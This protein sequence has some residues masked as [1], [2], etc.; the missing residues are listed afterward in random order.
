[1]KIRY[2]L[3]SLLFIMS[4]GTKIYSQ[5]DRIEPPFWWTEMKHGKLQLMVH[6]GNIADFSV[7]IAYDGVSIESVE[8]LDSDNYLFINLIISPEAK[9]G[10]VE[11]EFFDGDDP[12]TLKEYDL[13]E[14]EPGSA[15]R[16]GY[17]NS[18]VMYL[19]MPDRFVNGDPGNDT[20]EGMKEGLNRRKRFGRHGGDIAGIRNNLGYM[21][22]MGFTAIWLNPVLEN[23]MEEASYHGY[24]AT[25]FYRVDRRLGT[26]EEYVSL[27]S[28]AK[29]KGMK[30][31][32]DMIFNHCGSAHWWM[33]DLPSGDWINYGGKYHPSNHMRTVNQDP[34]AS[35][36]DKREMTDGWFVPAMPDL[37]QKNPFMAEYLIQNSIWWIEYAGI[38]GIRM[39]TYPY[40][41]KYMMAEWNRRISTEYPDFNIVGE[42]WSM[43]PAIVSYW[44][45]GQQNRD[46]YSGGLPGLM[47]FPLQDAVVKALNEKEEWGKGLVRIYEMLANDFLYPNPFNLVILPDNH[48]MPRFY[49]QLGM[50][51]YLFRNGIVFFLTTRG[52]PQIFYG[53]EILMTHK[54]GNDHGYIRKDF[55]GGWTGDKVNAFNG[56]GLGKEEK[57]MQNMFRRILNWRKQTPVIHTGRLLQF[58][59]EHGTYVYF[60]YDENDMVMVILNKNTSPYD[61]KLDRF[62]EMLHG[63][64]LARD[65]LSG[66]EYELGDKLSLSPGKPYI[67]EIE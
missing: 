12:V 27:V 31:I 55:P 16:K 61:L 52:V 19:I 50:N 11:L 9:P 21:T 30:V 1:M 3:L 40:P 44:Q 53:T 24:A 26:N 23:D 48:D 62:N 45:R 6:G 58:V 64:T 47:D 13:L 15:D 51:R 25:D 33:N 35:E 4:T 36:Y 22:D 67:L 38:S 7:N 18:D 28:E 41:D 8:R 17:D 37:N 46:G 39:D 29:A 65:I 2:L 49:M 34:Y 59:P 5:I 42:E 56:T 43:N 60:R 14:R 10:T 63:K 32:M 20:V 66:R 57:N 54:E